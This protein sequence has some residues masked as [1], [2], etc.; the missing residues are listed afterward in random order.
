MSILAH[1]TI[2]KYWNQ[3]WFPE[4]SGVRLAVCRITVIASQ[5]ILMI[6]HSSGLQIHINLVRNN[7]K[8]T[9][10]RV[11]TELVASILPEGMTFSPSFMTIIYAMTV[12]SALSALVGLRTRISCLI[13]AFGNAYLVSHSYSY[14]E[15]HHPEALTAIFLFLLPFS[16]CGRCL[17]VDAF[18]ADR[19]GNRTGS[20]CCRVVTRNAYWPLLLTQLLIAFSYFDAGLSKLYTGGLQW[21]NGYT[22]QRYLITDAIGNDLPVG[23]WVAQHHSICVMMSYSA[24]ALEVSFLVAIFF[25]RLLP[26]YFILGLLLHAGIYITQGA[27]FFETM[28]LYCVFVPFGRI[29]DSKSQPGKTPSQT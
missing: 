19:C 8:F 3:I 25:R 9:T 5:L 20:G 21:F 7:D 1:R 28:V 29:L 18:L 10:P 16:D 27:D 23:I 2:I 17:S 6:F 11:I 4:T 22:L 13:Y 24:V 15:F 12:V 14:G 26:I